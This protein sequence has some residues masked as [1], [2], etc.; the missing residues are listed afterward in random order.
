MKSIAQGCACEKSHNLKI[1]CSFVII[2]AY[3]AVYRQNVNLFFTNYFWA[4][5]GRPFRYD[6]VDGQRTPRQHP[7]PGR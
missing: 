4:R 1:T 6:A 5:K 2:R 3:I 7:M